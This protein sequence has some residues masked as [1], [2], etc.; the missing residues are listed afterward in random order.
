MPN[1]YSS[2]LRLI[3]QTT[4]EN[5]NLWGNY[6]NTNV[7]TLLEQAITGVGAIAV[8]GSSNYTLTA[9]NGA[10]DESRNAILNVTGTLTAAINIIC[11]T[12]SKVYIIKNGTT[13]GYA[14]TLKTASGTGISV[15]NGSTMLLYCDGTNVVEGVTSIG[16]Y[17]G[18]LAL[19]GNLSVAGTVSGTGFSNYLAS[20]PAIGGTSAAAGSFTNLAYTGTL[21]GSTGVMNIGSGQIY[22]DAYGNVGIGTQTPSQNLHIHVNGANFATIKLE[23]G[24]SSGDLFMASDGTFNLSQ[25][26]N[27]ALKFNVYSNERMRIDASGNVGIGES[28]PSSYAALAVRKAV[29]NTSAVFSDAVNSTISLKHS[30]GVAQIVTDAANLT[31]GSNNAEIM[32]TDSSGNLLVGYTSSN[33]SYKLQVNSQIFA[34]SSTIATSDMRYK[35]EIKPLTNAIDLVNKLNPVSFKWK[36]HPVHNFDTTSKTTGFLAQEVQSALEGTEFVDAIVKSNT[37][38]LEAAE[39]ETIVISPAVEEVKDEEGNIITEA[40]AEVT[41]QKLIKE[42]VTEEFLGIAE[43]NLISILTK[44]IQE[45]SAEVDELKKQLG[46]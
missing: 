33:G 12:V 9:T 27:A 10:S 21:T 45:L 24:L 17:V 29:G 15:P 23:N 39:Y 44:A 7:G 8:S 32:R 14:V 2:N 30:S 42:A 3:I 40:V 38:T 5:Q 20:P 41:E 43:G 18:N 16:T 37:C 25:Y 46:K 19:A 22:K 34:T 4:G 6:T 31:L 26:N 36:E 11:P 28:S 35:E 1:S 13:G